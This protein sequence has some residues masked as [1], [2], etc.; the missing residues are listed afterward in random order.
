[1]GGFTEAD[2]YALIDSAA[3]LKPAFIVPG[4]GSVGTLADLAAY[5]QYHV[6]LLSGVKA[7]VAAGKTLP[8]LQASLTLDQYK[9]WGSYAQFRPLNIQGAYAYV[10]KK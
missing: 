8:E 4:H 9:D 7:G 3:A 5:K 1:M 2:T 10:T 6:D